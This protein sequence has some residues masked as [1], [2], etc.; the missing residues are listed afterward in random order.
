MDRAN[1]P[2]ALGAAAT[3]AVVGF[4]LVWIRLAFEGGRWLQRRG[5][6]MQVNAPPLT[7][8]L[9]P[10]V[11]WR[12]LAAVVV[13]GAGI[14]RADAWSRRL[15]WRRLLWLSFGVALAWAGALAFWDG[16]GGFTRSPASPVDYLSALP[17]IDSTGAFLRTFVERIDLYPAHVRAH[18]P[19]MVLLVIGLD[20]VGLGTQ[21]WI[22][23]LELVAGASSVP[24][25]LVAIREVAGEARARGAAPFLML[26]SG[27]VFWTSGD[28]VFLGLSA[29]A[30]SLLILATGR[31][32]RR[33][34]G[35]ALGGGALAGAA[36]FASY[37]LVLL[38]LVPLAV[39]ISRRR[40]RPLALA[41]IP[42][43]LWFVG[44]AAAGFW[45]L[46]GLAA[47]RREYA[48]SLARVRPYAYFV[49][50]NPA[51][52]LVALGPAVWVSLVS[53]RDRGLWLL[54]GAG[55]A[56]VFLADLSGLSK[57]EVERIW[58]PFTPWVVA[59]T[60]AAFSGDGRRRGWIAAG[61]VWAIAVQMAVVSPW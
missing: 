26:G 10:R 4:V 43:A 48:E 56:A 17:L 59:L 47:T 22:G 1:E 6:R 29:W 33:G 23:V 18:P 60:G 13:G 40:Y 54:A 3:T 19:G 20:R 52:F 32:D 15:G 57:G 46:D 2:R 9:D 8:N 38:A 44:F 7:G 55:L 14:W 49:L 12:S 34:D 50:A 5:Y 36:L 16:V 21:G 35:L 39:A 24:A 25:V 58:L 11:S 27:A 28:A 30:A 51:A 42:V 45:W 41:A 37:G 61:V 53:A 31:S